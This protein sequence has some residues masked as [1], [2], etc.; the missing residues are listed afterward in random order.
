MTIKGGDYT[1]A[2]FYVT[3]DTAKVIISGGTF[4]SKPDADTF[5]K[6]GTET[7]GVNDNA[8]AATIADGYEAVQNTDG[9]WTVQAKTTTTEN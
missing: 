1:Q 5:L 6:V 2:N 3:T 8:R 9:T 7:Q 4:K